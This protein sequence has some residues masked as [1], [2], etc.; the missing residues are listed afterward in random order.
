[1]SGFLSKES[2]S[3]VYVNSDERAHVTRTISRCTNTC[4]HTVRQRDEGNMFL[5]GQQSHL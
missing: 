3:I 1:M 5:Y 4:V 2:S